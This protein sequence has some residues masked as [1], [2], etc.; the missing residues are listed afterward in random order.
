ML[1]IVLLLS[2]LNGLAS[3]KVQASVQKVDEA[4][5]VVHHPKHE[6]PPEASSSPTFFIKSQWSRDDLMPTLAEH[7]SRVM[8]EE[9][10]TF[11][12]VGP[13]FNC[14]G[15]KKFKNLPPRP[16][17]KPYLIW[18]NAHK[19]CAGS[20]LHRKDFLFVALDLRNYELNNNEA[21]PMRGITMAPP[22]F[23][24]GPTA[25]PDLR[26]K[27]FLT[28]RGQVRNGFQKSSTVRSDLSKAFSG[29]KGRSDV[30]VEF[31][32]E[33]HAGTSQF[34]RYSQ[35]DKDRFQELTN[36]SFFLN[37][38]GD[39]RY[40]NG[41]A[42]T[43]GACAVPVIMADGLTLP[44]EELIDW[45]KASVRVPEKVAKQGP[46]AVLNALPADQLKIG[47]MRKEACRIYDE[48][49]STIERR[50][51][52]MLKAAAIRMTKP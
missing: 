45:S 39:N 33:N 27:Y 21:E 25:D 9:K 43:L 28:Y 18:A 49:F 3:L 15:A 41:F 4:P 5:F 24:S 50:I 23:H 40:M 37:P 34:D 13:M 1:G 14:A 19:T 10:A 8:D 22:Y 38:H 26:A 17:N 2:C 29:Y 44:F 47:S 42:S 12:I 6:F 11:V 52:S 20:M 36:T 51:D 7:P 48:H 31:L 16:A 30:A 32:A 46:D 35:A